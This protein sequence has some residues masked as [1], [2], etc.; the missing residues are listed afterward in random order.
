MMISKKLCVVCCSLFLSATLWAQK[1]LSDDLQQ[2]V[3]QIAATI[4]DDP[5]SAIKAF[6][7]LT[8]GK[9]KK[10]VALV[11]AIGNAFL[12]NDKV[13]QAKSYAT[14]A[15]EMDS[16]NAGYCILAGDIALKEKKVGVAGGLYEQ[17]IM[18]DRDNFEAYRKYARLYLGVNPELSVEKLLEFK[19]KH[20]EEVNVN[21]ELGNAY[22]L[23]KQY[24]NAK[25][26]YDAFMQVGTPDEQDYAR[27][28]NLLFLSKD[29][30]ESLETA[31]KGLA[32]NPEDHLMKRLLMYNNYEMKKYPEGIAAA[33]KFFAVEDTTNFVYL[34]YMYYG[35][36]LL[37]QKQDSQALEQYNKALALDPNG[38][39][40]EIQKEL[41]GVYEGMLNYPAAIDS[42]KKY[43]EQAKSEEVTD[44]FML[45]RLY[46]MAASAPETNANPADTTATGIST[47]KAGYIA[48]A[49]TIFAQVA[50]RVPDSY[51]GSF[52][53]ARVNSLADPE[54]T[55]GLAKPYYEQA[56]AILEANP[57]SAPANIVECLRYL[58]YY[59]VVKE[60]YESSMPYWNKVL[61]ISP[62]DAAAKQVME[63]VT[64]ATK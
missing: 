35:R 12:D 55:L 48:E 58:G 25:T 50:E 3:N 18:A 16:R 22:Y 7:E 45:G 20:P 26:A 8:K 36:L 13:D 17:A 1:P 24:G 43:L 40:P 19:E 51:L 31:T 59:Y 41:S 29:Y 27:Y 53:R 28:S 57:N 60:E 47:V 33:E 52:W 10:N 9:N 56:L 37:T 39:H 62:D 34:D 14:K 15:G 23:M 21:R 61:E 6:D 4:K 49:D 38:E 54:T 32:L 2:Q 42:Y 44:L 63:F 5:A 11:V 64:N 46:Y 30:A